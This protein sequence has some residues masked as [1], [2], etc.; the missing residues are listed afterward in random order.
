MVQTTTNPIANR[1]EEQQLLHRL[2]AGET[3]AFWQLF[4]PCR[5]YLFRCCLKWTNG[6]ST[7]AEDLLSQA[8]LKAFKKAQKYAGEIE[9]FKS[10]LTTL[11]RN[12]WL[13]LKRRGGTISVED[14]EVYGEQHELGLVSV[15]QTSDRALEE[16]D[17]KRVIRAAIDELANWLRETFIFHYYQGLSNQ[18]IAERQE[19]SGANVRQRISR[20][21]KILALELRGYFIGDVAKEA[22]PVKVGPKPAKSKKAVGR[23][24]KVEASA[25]KTEPSSSGV[26]TEYSNPKPEEET[27]FLPRTQSRGETTDQEAIEFN[28]EPAQTSDFCLNI[29]H[30]NQKTREKIEFFAQFASQKYQKP[31]F[32]PTLQ[33]HKPKP[34][35]ETEFF[36]QFASQKH[37]LSILLFLRDNLSFPHLR[38]S[39]RDR[40]HPSLS[41]PH[42]RESTFSSTNTSINTGINSS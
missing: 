3:R 11:T 2:A 24:A 17:K 12:F 1:A 7:E 13:D 20:A 19:I 14:I 6:N 26:N 18:E 32:S 30:E 35:K 36:A 39:K 42:L 8:M 9:N 23:V 4:Q 21:R 37:L 38:E 28:R 25:P 22:D 29:Q 34:R 40:L 33:N 5:D 10:W 15:D 27:K 16:D 31:G 41:F